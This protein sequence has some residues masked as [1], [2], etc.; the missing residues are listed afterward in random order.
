MG[1]YPSNPPPDP[2]YQLVD[3]EGY[4]HVEKRGLY[5]SKPHRNPG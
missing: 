2:K 3:P 5:L 1:L 4:K